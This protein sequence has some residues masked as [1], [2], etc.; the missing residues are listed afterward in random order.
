MLYV[1]SESY[2]QE[3]EK[4]TQ[5]IEYSNFKNDENNYLNV[6]SSLHQLFYGIFK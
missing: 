2:I 3:F 1:E 5:D 4:T 6:W